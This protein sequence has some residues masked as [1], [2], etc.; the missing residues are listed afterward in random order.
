MEGK[1]S[2]GDSFTQ[3]EDH[4]RRVLKR[5]RGEELEKKEDIN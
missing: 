4:G 3:N 5:E 1:Y 2:M